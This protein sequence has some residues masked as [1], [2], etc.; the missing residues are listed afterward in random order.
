[1]SHTD[2][3]RKPDPVATLP[4]TNNVAW[5][6]YPTSVY[7]CALVWTPSTANAI[8]LIISPKNNTIT[9]NNNIYY[10]QYKNEKNSVSYNITSHSAE[11]ATRYDRH[12]RKYYDKIIN[13]VGFERVIFRK[14]DEQSLFKPYFYFNGEQYMCR[15]NA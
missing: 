2:R 3:A 5:E 13:Y 14:G 11:V 6:D 10:T 8:K 7:D 15:R 1:V 12:S 4:G 9:V